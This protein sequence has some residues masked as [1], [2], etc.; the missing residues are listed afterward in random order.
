VLVTTR[1]LGPGQEADFFLRIEGT[2][3]AKLE[4]RAYGKNL[5][6]Q[7]RKRGTSLVKPK[8]PKGLCSNYRR[9]LAVYDR[10]SIRCA[11]WERGLQGV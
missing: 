10:L 7:K 8:H 4:L 1:L 5:T 9:L 6:S 2:K 11:G 3:S